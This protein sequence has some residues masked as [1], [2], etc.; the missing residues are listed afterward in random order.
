MPIK[1]FYRRN[2][3]ICKTS[4]V[5][6]F[7]RIRNSKIDSYSYLSYFS[8]L[9]NVSVG[10]YCSIAQGVSIGLGFH[11]TD[12]ISTSPIFYSPRNP[13]RKSRVKK[14]TFEDLKP[15]IIGND[16]WIGANVVVLDG[17]EIGHGSIVGA[18][19]VVTKNVKPY[20]IIGG[21][22]ATLI[23]KRFTD[24]EIE[25]LLALEWWDQPDHFFE[26]LHV[27]KIFSKKASMK[28]LKDL[29]RFLR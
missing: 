19:S 1:F 5:F 16:V 18:N 12:F 28:E 20:S 10:K 14:R 21:V 23:R 13:L 2:S 8:N 24:D 29:A 3:K 27:K 25:F 17:V 11:P 7:S 26:D 15:C 4:V 22:P 6:P 9:N